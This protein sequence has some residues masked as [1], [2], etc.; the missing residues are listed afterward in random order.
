MRM[1]SRGSMEGEQLDDDDESP[2]RRRRQIAG[3][4]ISALIRIDSRL[5]RAMASHDNRPTTTPGALGRRSLSPPKTATETSPR[6]KTTLTDRERNSVTSMGHYMETGKV[7]F[8][9][10][11]RFSSTHGK[12]IELSSDRRTACRTDSFCNGITFSNR[13]IRVGEKVHLKMNKVQ[14]GWRGVLK[15]GFTMTNPCTVDSDLLPEYAVPDTSKQPRYWALPIMEK[16]AQ[17]DNIFSFYLTEKGTVNYSINLENKGVFLEGL[18]D[19]K[20]LWALVDVFGKT[21]EISIV[22]EEAAK[23]AVEAFEKSVGNHKGDGD[24]DSDHSSRIFFNNARGTNIRLEDKHKVVRRKRNTFW[25]SL[26]F[27]SRPMVTNE[28][29]FVEVLEV[30]AQYAGSMGFGVTSCDPAKLASDTEKT[31]LPDNAD[32]LVMK[33]TELSEYWKLS[34]E[35]KVPSSGD[36]LSFMIT[37]EGNVHYDVNGAGAMVLLNVDLNIG[38]LWAL[39][40]VYGS[41]QAIRLLGVIKCEDTL[42]EE[43]QTQEEDDLEDVLMGTKPRQAEQDADTECSMCYKKER[44]KDSVVY[45]CAH[46]CLC[47]LCAIKLKKYIPKAYCPVCSSPV[48]EVIRLLA[49]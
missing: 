3:W 14:L 5:L 20:P 43:E 31:G 1:D 36:K 15:L 44:P 28:M 30:N 39:F 13:P 49:F 35:L 8:S 46:V 37:E 10:P 21:E 7:S 45:P 40:D 2:R 24:E 17:K 12:N 42:R 33:R 48:K 22:D 26:A 29:L 38:P 47:H 19:T 16:Y 6:P 9:Q 27:T 11:I 23:E 25:N 41:T 34:R 4:D 32:I 18:D